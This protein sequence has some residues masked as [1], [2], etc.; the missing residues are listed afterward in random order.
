MPGY[1]SV[2]V[3]YHHVRRVSVV[4]CGAWSWSLS[5]ELIGR[6]A[7]EDCGCPLMHATGPL[8][9][10]RCL[11]SDLCVLFSSH[12]CSLAPLGMRYIELL[13]KRF[14]TRYTNNPTFEPCGHYIQQP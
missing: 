1:P 14:K 3:V 10:T 7:F 11:V 5:N 2:V 13:L 6:S 4:C 12:G 8:G 9:G